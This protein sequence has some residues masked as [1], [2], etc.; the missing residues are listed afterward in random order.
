MSNGTIK[1]IANEAKKRLKNGY[2]E[3]LYKNRD[4][5]LKIAKEKGVAS[6]I[7]VDAYKQ[8]FDSS[9]TKSSNVLFD[10]TEIYK[11]VYDIVIRENEGEMVY[12]PLGIIKNDEFYNTLDEQGKQ[13]YIF[14]L[15]D[16]YID[17]RRSIERE[18][19][20]KSLKR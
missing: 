4:E 10:E 14:N 5:D 9:K 11:K 16:I 19:K 13:K 17:M 12:N 3:N 6:G 2:W 7:V 18:L 1:R 8:K 20:I 15:S